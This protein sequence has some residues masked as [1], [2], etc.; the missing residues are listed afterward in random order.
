MISI[1]NT[2]LKLLI[3]VILVLVFVSNSVKF[4]ADAAKKGCNSTVFDVCTNRLLMLG[5]DTFVFP[6]SLKQMNARCK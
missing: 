4:S 5:D 3:G 1:S 6:T 2:N